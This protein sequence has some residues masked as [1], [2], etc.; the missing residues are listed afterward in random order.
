M[1]ARKLSDIDRAEISA[2]KAR[3]KT[4]ASIAVKFRIS[5]AVVRRIAKLAARGDGTSILYAARS[6]RPAARGFRVLI[7]GFEVA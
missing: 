2:M 5:N 7:D 3:G 4:S 1:N 6:E